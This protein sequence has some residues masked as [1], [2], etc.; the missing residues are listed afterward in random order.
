MTDHAQFTDRW[1]KRGAFGY[2]CHLY[3]H[4][5]QPPNEASVSARG[6]RRCRKQPA[7]RGDIMIEPMRN[8]NWMLC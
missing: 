8:L 3:G 1:G 2:L 6:F 7:S 4:E 5:V